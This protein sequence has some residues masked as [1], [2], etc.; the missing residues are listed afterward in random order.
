MDVVLI[1]THLT[2]EV[3]R[4]SYALI[5]RR[6]IIVTMRPPDLLTFRLKGTRTTYPLSIIGAFNLAVK[7]E[8]L[9]LI[10][11]KMEERKASRAAR[12]I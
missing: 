4:V 6:E 7:V 3:R 5:R 2:K 9:A 11:C 12:K 8:A 10:K 1:M